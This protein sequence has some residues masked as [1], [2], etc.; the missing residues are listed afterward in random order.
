MHQ[1]ILG[2]IYCHVVVL[3]SHVIHGWPSAYIQWIV[4][5]LEAPEGFVSLLEAS[6]IIM[7]FYFKYIRRKLQIHERTYERALIPIF[8][9]HSF[10]REILRSRGG[11]GVARRHGPQETQPFMA[12]QVPWSRVPGARA[13]CHLYSREHQVM[14]IYIYIYIYI[15]ECPYVSVNTCMYVYCA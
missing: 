14:H 7:N 1:C 13:L 6:V 8:D 4:I 9:S 3:T 10:G 15:Y 5:L 2:T 12:P 11:P